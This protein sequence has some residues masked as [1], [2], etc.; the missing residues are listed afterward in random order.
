MSIAEDEGVRDAEWYKSPN[1]MASLI[2]L[3]F[4]HMFS[5]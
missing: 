3:P 4:V 2:S 1:L 5:R